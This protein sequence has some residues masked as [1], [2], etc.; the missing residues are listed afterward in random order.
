MSTAIPLTDE[1]FQITIQRAVQD[2]LRTMA[3]MKAELSR[4]TRLER[5][6]SGAPET[7]ISAPTGDVI[8]GT[9]GFVG[10]LDGL[11]YLYLPVTFA[12]HLAGT[13]LGMTPAELKEAGDEVV[14]DAVG[15]L[16]N[17]T[18]GAFK[19][20]LCD[21]GYPCK[22][23]IPSI[24]RGANFSIQPTASATRRLYEFDI[25]GHVLVA[26]LLVKEND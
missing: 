2:V 24:M 21:Q 9:V 22:L 26:D 5:A 23:T 6:S 11:I 13:M 15:E 20:V 25:Q 7:S 16:T 8:I 12:Q 4:H 14:N 17:M 10:E 19:N 18:V 1:L 3:T